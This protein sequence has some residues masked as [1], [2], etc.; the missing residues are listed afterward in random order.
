MNVT[1]KKQIHRY[2]EQTSSCQ[3]GD[4]RWGRGLRTTKY[5]H[6]TNKLQGYI[7]QHREYSQYFIITLKGI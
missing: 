1:K 6:K 7:V 5:Y 3:W 4:G 2:K